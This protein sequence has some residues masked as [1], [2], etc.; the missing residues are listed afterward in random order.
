MCSVVGF[1][2]SGWRG[3]GVGTQTCGEWLELRLKSK[4]ETVGLGPPA[5]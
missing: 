5:Y 2:A 1:E 4:N 3:V